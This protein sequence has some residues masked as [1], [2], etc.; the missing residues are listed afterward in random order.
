MN[1]NFTVTWSMDINGFHNWEK[2]PYTTDMPCPYW[3]S[4][5]IGEFNISA[6]VDNGS[7]SKVITTKIKVVPSKADYEFGKLY[8]TDFD[9]I[10]G[11]VTRIY[12]SMETKRKYLAIG[13][14][15]MLGAA[16][17]IHSLQRNNI[18]LDAKVSRQFPEAKKLIVEYK[19]RGILG[20]VVILHLGTNGFVD[21]NVVRSTL[22]LLKDCQKVFI[23][24]LKVPRS[25]EE[26]NNSIFKEVINEYTNVS[27]IDW[28]S[29]SIGAKENFVNDGI[30]LTVKGINLYSQLIMDAVN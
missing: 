25:Y 7:E 14:S 13:D 8:K 9:H 21:K 17:K 24:T 3:Y 18:N 30:H 1:Q 28:Y 23:I 11:Y 29:A 15:V 5:D 12:P 19:E 20:D 6:K 4:G 10:K 26:H 2:H 27:L 16:R 22:D